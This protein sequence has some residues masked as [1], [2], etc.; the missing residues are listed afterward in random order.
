MHMLRQRCSLSMLYGTCENLY[1]DVR[2]VGLGM[3]NILHMPFYLSSGVL[4][5]ILYR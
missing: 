3:P 5:S 1:G 2:L 4:R